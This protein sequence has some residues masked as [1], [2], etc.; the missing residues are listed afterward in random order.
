MA[1]QTS[2][3]PQL[4]STCAS[5]E[6]LGRHRSTYTPSRTTYHVSAFINY[7][8]PIANHRSPI[9][10]HPTS[11]ILYTPY[12][13]Q[14]GRTEGTSSRLD[15]GNTVHLLRHGGLHA[16]LQILTPTLA[17]SRGRQRCLVH[18]PGE[19][20]T[21]LQDVITSAQGTTPAAAG[22]GGRTME[23]R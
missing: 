22:R 7:S 11:I 17:T 4:T 10:N 20:G 23:G 12:H 6:R 19:A 21:L 13:A 5:A 3:R 2:Q 9:V 16:L 18:T 14:N 8:L 15:Y 1:L